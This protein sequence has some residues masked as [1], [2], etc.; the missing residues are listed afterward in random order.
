M[1]A[2]QAG[3]G[4]MELPEGVE[5]AAVNGPSSVVLSGDEEAVLAEGG[6]LVG[7]SCKRLS[8][9]HAFHSHLME[10]VLEDSGRCWSPS[11]PC[12]EAGVRLD[13]DRHPGG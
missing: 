8:V 6:P 12:A 7:P 3:E 9:S 13:G 5:L 11:P 2:V 10:P 4:E 1:V